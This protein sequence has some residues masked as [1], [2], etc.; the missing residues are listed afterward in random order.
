MDPQGENFVVEEK[1]E[2]NNKQQVKVEQKENLEIADIYEED[3]EEV[4]E[5]EE[6][7]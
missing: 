7:K 2:L 1:V 4:E 5:E 3:E 6:E